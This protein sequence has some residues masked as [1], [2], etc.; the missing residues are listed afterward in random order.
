VIGRE[1]GCVVGVLGM[2]IGR[3]GDVGPSLQYSSITRCA[4]L[5]CENTNSNRA[6]KQQRYAVCKAES[7]ISC[8]EALC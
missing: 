4:K 5:L 3:V 2:R 8:V 7:F 6:S 1:I